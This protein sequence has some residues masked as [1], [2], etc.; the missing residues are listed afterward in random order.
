MT[1]DSG[2][3]T[4]GPAPAEPQPITTA[5]TSTTPDVADHVCRPGCG[6]DH[7]KEPRGPS[8]RDIDK[9]AKK[10]NQSGYGGIKDRFG[11][12]FVI[13]NTRT[14]MVVELKAASPLHACN[15]IGWRQRHTRVLEVKEPK[16]EDANGGEPTATAGPAATTPAPAATA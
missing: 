3:T 9:D 15:L 2:T 1:G 6:H 5:T 16:R 4:I 8:R 10:L 7:G 12:S 14:G 13:M 11:T